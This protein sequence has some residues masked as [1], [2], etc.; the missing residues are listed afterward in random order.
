MFNPKSEMGPIFFA[1]HQHHQTRLNLVEMTLAPSSDAALGAFV[2]AVGLAFLDPDLAT[3][4]LFA[5][6]TASAVWAFFAASAA[7]ADSCL[8]LF[9]L[10]GLSKGIVEGG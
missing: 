3:F 2:L 10:I 1:E 5:A 8:F 4:A 9:F 7:T 6:L